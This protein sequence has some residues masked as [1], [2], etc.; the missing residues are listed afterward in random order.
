ML[1]NRGYLLSFFLQCAGVLWGLAWW[2]FV[3]AGMEGPFLPQDQLPNGR[4]LVT[5]VQ[6][7]G[8]S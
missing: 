3:G 2:L 4:G 1:S 5:G 7:A 8:A 6:D